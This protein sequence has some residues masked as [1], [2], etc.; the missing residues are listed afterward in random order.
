M[1]ADQ[2]LV[3]SIGE[4]AVNAI[5]RDVLNG[6]SVTLDPNSGSVI[7]D[8]TL[9]NP[10]RAMRHR[11]IARVMDRVYPIFED[12]DVSFSFLFSDHVDKNG[13]SAEQGA[14]AYAYV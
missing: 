11:A 3:S 9:H 8:I 6:L 1:D 2:A 5:G 10:D 4:N 13:A 14:Y 12:D 7:F